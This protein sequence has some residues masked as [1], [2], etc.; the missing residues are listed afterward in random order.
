MNCPHGPFDNCR[1]DELRQE[2]Q[3]RTRHPNTAVSDVIQQRINAMHARAA[4]NRGD[5]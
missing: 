1:C 4:R 3:D 2:H 5:A